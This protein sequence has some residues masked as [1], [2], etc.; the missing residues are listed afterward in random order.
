MLTLTSPHDTPAHRWPAG[1]KLALLLL[2]SLLV[3][4]L[5]L[6][7]VCAAL[8]LVAAAAW[9]LGLIWPWAR[10]L[11]MIWPLALVLILWHG[12]SGTW[13]SGVLAVLRMAA[14]VGA[15]NLMTMTTR[16]S[17]LQAVMLL[18]WEALSVAFRARSDRRPG[19]RIAAPAVL[20]ALDD[21][22]RV[23]EALR[24]RGGAG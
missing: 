16:L 19:W 14:S 3:F 15:A 2:F 17:D 7:G 13:G 5:P 10:L 18:R 12:L 4:A 1:A 22:E 9:A 11:R 20:A 6:V 24:A 23:A 21:A 8:G